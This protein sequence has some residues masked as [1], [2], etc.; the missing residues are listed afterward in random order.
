MYKLITMHKTYIAIGAYMASKKD[1]DATALQAE[2]ALFYRITKSAAHELRSPMATITMASHA[3]EKIMADVFNGYKVA[4]EHKLI[5]PSVNPAKFQLIEGSFVGIKKAV[6]ESQNFLTSL[7]RYIESYAINPKD[8]KPLS[9]TTCVDRLLSNYAFNNDQE[10]AL[11][12]IDLKHEFTFK[13][14]EI[15][16][17]D[18]LAGLLKN[19]LFYIKQ[20]G[21]GD[22]HIWTETEKSANVLHFKDTGAGMKS[23]NLSHVFDR[24]FSR[25]DDGTKAGL[26]FCKEMISEFGGSMTCD[27]KEG[28]YT[29]FIIQLPAI[30]E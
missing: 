18:L 11:V 22:I 10:R 13:V 3:T 14:P 20:A 24:L 21:K 25:R 12:H 16:I 4:I 28:E 30:V 15:F 23:E 27:S 6:E 26:G 1:A 2:K 9:I 8:I 17:E 19:A 5:E 29:H 7:T